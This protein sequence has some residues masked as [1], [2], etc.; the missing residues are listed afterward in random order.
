MSFSYRACDSILTYINQ[1]ALIFFPG[2]VVGRLFD[3]GYFR[4]V[5]M[6]SS[7]LLITTT[8]L[9]AECTEYWQFLLCQGIASGVCRP[10]C[11]PHYC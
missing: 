3:L 2:L 9:A 1:Y 6:F 10:P 5:F 4:Y 11:F 8:F 7:A